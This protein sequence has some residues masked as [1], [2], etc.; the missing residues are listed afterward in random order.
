MKIL[1]TGATGFIGKAVLEKLIK[2]YSSS[3]IIALSS[4][5]IEG[6]RTIPSKGYA[7]SKEYLLENGCED[8]EVLMHIGAFTPKSNHEVDNIELTTENVLSTK[9]VLESNLSKLKKII[10]ISTLDVYTNTDGFLDERSSTMP[11][12]L[13]GWS[14]LYCEKMIS[15]YCAQENIAYEIL[16]LGHVYGPGEEKYRKVMPVMLQ[17]A[18]QGK[19]LTI[20]GDGE[21]VR[22]FIFIDDVVTAIVRSI[23]LYTSEVINIVGSETI[24]INELANMIR[25]YTNN[26][27][28][29]V[30]ISSDIENIN[31]IFDNSKMRRLLLSE[32]TPLKIG[33]RQEYDYLR[34]KES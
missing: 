30:Y 25:T 17:N 22:S 27:I 4:K 10:Y 1:I 3:D 8:V 15:N 12:G 14:K 19:N 32:L 31:Y 33:L 24:T 28:S 11:S 5:Q 6:I 26:Q 21:A 2:K 29:I 7:F 9:K 18:I 34:N 16:R 20:Y 23:D 13:Y